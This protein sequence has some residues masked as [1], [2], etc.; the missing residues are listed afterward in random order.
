M[1]Q[2]TY[3]TQE[4]CVQF[5]AADF[6]MHSIALECLGD[7]VNLCFSVENAGDVIPSNP[8]IAVTVWNSNPLHAQALP[9]LTSNI[10][11]APSLHQV[12]T[13]CIHLPASQLSGQVYATINDPGDQP[14]P[15]AF[16]LTDV[17]ECNYFNNLDSLPLE[18]INIDV[19][20]GPDLIA[21]LGEVVTIT[22]PGH[23]DWIE[24]S[25][26]LAVDCDTCATIHLQPS[27]PI[28]LEVM[29]GNGSCVGLDTISINVTY[30]V[31]MELDT[32]L[33]EGQVFSFQ[34]SMI[35]DDGDY[36]FQE[37]QCDTAF[38]WHVTFSSPDS[39]WQSASLCAGDSLYFDGQWIKDP[40][41]Y[42]HHA[43]NQM[44]CDSLIHLNLTLEAYLSKT[45]TIILCNGDSVW[46]YSRWVKHEGTFLDTLPGPL[47]D[48]VAQTVVMVANPY[49]I[50]STL[51]ICPGDSVWLEGHWVTSSDSIVE[52]LLS[53]AGCDSMVTTIV[54]V[55]VPPPSPQLSMTCDP[56]EVTVVMTP[57]FGWQYT[58]DDGQQTDQVIYHSSGPHSVSAEHST[59]CKILFQFMVDDIPDPDVFTLLTDTTILE[60]SA[61]RINLPLSPV[62]W[63]AHWS[64]SALFV[65]D[66]CLNTTLWPKELTP[67]EVV[68]THTSGCQYT[69][70][71]IV[72]LEPRVELYVPN[73]FSPNDDGINDL[74]LVQS[75]GDRLT[76]VEAHLFDRWGND[77]RQWTQINR[78]EWDGRFHGQ[79]LNPGVFAYSI[80]YIDQEGLEQSIT[81]NVTLVR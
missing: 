65:C 46:V 12:D 79:M 59:G 28:Q 60:G 10:V 81:G 71:F 69:I 2:A 55:P 57:V 76:I 45:N 63:S 51:G 67:V 3:R 42:M 29:A 17:I 78:L 44:G 66:S 34:D 48:T 14:S 7:S 74:W 35:T 16:P 25:P 15:I 40:G 32:L 47:C 80:R 18:D 6:V 58:W 5:P 39:T 13:F 64:P 77:I 21:C 68:L 73:V 70:G 1:T 41:M 37:S 24:W 50:N 56:P 23:F 26:A 54:T 62:Y 36:W 52:H 19:N 27:A 9:V 49:Q 11:L 22:L 72:D 20:A 31:N 38:T 43:I 8:A 75:P 30:P 4:G 33:C 61:L 53:I